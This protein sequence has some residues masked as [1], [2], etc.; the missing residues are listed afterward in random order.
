MLL[1]GWLVVVVDSILLSFYLFHSLPHVPS[2]STVLCLYLCF[3]GAVFASNSAFNSDIS[4]WNTGAVKYMSS[5]KSFIIECCFFCLCQ[6]MLFVCLLILLLT[7]FFFLFIYSIHCH[8]FHQPPL[9]CVCTSAF[10]VQCSSTIQP[11]IRTFQNGTRVPSPLCNTVSLSQS[12][13]VSFVC[14]N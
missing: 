14:V 13:V 6:V 12:S 5:S 10:I 7:A 3:Y 1:V 11:S 9:F 8:T 2:T 4:K